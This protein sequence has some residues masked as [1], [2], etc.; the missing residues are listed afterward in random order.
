MKTHIQLILC[1]I[2]I[3]SSLSKSSA[4]TF[5]KKEAR[6]V[7]GMKYGFDN[8]IKLSARYEHRLD[9]NF[10]HYKKSIPGL[11]IS[12]EHEFD[13]NWVFIPGFE[14]RFEFGDFPSVHDFRY[15][16]GV[17]F[18]PDEKFKINY[19][20]ML[21]QNLMINHHSDYFLRNGL[22]LNYDLNKSL[23]F[24]IFTENYQELNSGINF[25]TQKYGLGTVYL[26]NKRNEFELKFDF[27]Q[28]SDK[29]NSARILVGY[30]YI[31]K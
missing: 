23:S 19:T 30:N 1:I 31:L 21:Q 28:H 14:Y 10:N 15:S 24:S 12:Y 9:H 26:L 7:A 16:A 6:I 20:A 3:L 5:D 4:Q 8:G 22:E 17:D 18:K 13:T 27:R 25:H 2:T 29:T 11:K